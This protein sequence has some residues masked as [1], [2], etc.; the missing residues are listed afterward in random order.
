M[1][2]VEELAEENQFDPNHLLENVTCTVLVVVLV[3]DD[4]EVS[5]DEEWKIVEKV[6]RDESQ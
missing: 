5:N 2:D 1:V 4:V 3:E 6:M